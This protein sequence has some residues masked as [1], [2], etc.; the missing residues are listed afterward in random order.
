MYQ[1][2][3]LQGKELPVPC[4]HVNKVVG[5]H[6][7]KGIPGCYEKLLMVKAVRQW[8]RELGGD[9]PP[10]QAL[11]RALD[12]HLASLGPSRSVFQDSGN[13]ELHFAARNDKQ[14]NHECQ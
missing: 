11:E 12:L 1:E 8:D 14:I 10:V 9:S 13:G 2:L 5:L 4:V 3:L 7:D 6:P